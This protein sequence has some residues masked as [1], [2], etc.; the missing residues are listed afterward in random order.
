M[1]LRL[2]G[3]GL[4]LGAAF[5]LALLAVL[6]VS[7]RAVPARADAGVEG[8]GPQALMDRISKDLFQALDA[9]RAAIRKDS[10]QAY[11]IIDRILLPHFDV[12]FAAQRVLAQHWRSATPEQRKR[13]IAALYSALRRSY[14]G[15]IAD[16]TADR[17]KLL[18]FRGDPAATQAMVHTLVRRS[19]GTEVH[20]DYHLRKTADGWKADDVIIE[21]LSYVRTFQ[22]DL[23][24]AISKQGLEAVIARLEREGLDAKVP[25]EGTAAAATRHE[26]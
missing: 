5:V 19:S 4:A 18:P 24:G 21:G 7:A 10:E 11:P 8:P 16:F 13:F 2:K 17:L 1:T 26:P 12:D 3:P 14:G 23:G 15:A 6:A 22:S 20:V 9:N 25:L